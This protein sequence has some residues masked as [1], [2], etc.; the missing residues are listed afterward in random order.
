ME[1]SHLN[2]SILL[3]L[4]GDTYFYIEPKIQHFHL[5]KIS[6]DQDNGGKLKDAFVAESQQPSNVLARRS[7]K[8]GP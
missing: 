1:L 7:E 4:A 3:G 5:I 6:H 8:K 2:C